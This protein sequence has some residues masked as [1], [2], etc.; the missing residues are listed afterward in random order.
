MDVRELRDE[1]PDAATAL[2]AIGGA[3]LLLRPPEGS[4]QEALVEDGW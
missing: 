3:A 4:S 2:P 1:E